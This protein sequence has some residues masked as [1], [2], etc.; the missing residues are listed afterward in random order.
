MIVNLNGGFDSVYATDPKLRTDVESWVDVPFSRDAIVT[1][2]NLQL[3]PHFAPLAPFSG[4]MADGWR[5]INSN[6]GKDH[7]AQGV[8]PVLRPGVPNGRCS[9][10]PHGSRDGRPADLDPDG[11]FGG[12]LPLQHPATALRLVDERAGAIRPRQW[13]LN[14]YWVGGDLAQYT[15]GF[16]AVVALEALSACK[17]AG[18][19]GADLDACLA[20][21]S[22]PALLVNEPAPTGGPA[23]AAQSGSAS[24][25]SGSARR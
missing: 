14:E 15:P 18:H 13:P 16:A 5:S 21:A 6:D 19:T 3:G 24:L 11:R 9:V 22:D 10:R 2:G 12:A 25:S 8:V 20:R 4:R 1:S 23:P 7:L 17:Q